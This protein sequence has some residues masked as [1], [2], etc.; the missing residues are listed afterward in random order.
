MET[1][2]HVDENLQVWDEGDLCLDAQVELLCTTVA[3]C[4]RI[5]AW[6][7]KKEVMLNLFEVCLSLASTAV[8]SERAKIKE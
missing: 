6:E 8:A 5:K 2:Y 3:V 7:N 4:E 1:R